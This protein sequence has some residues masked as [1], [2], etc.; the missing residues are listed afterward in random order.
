[1][2]GAIGTALVVAQMAALALEFDTR[3]AMT[4]GLIAAG[5]WIIHAT[6]NRDFWLL[7]TNASVGGF[8]I[9]GLV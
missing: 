6:K 2:I 8:A 4:I 3:L 1:M 9:W 5:C 7:I